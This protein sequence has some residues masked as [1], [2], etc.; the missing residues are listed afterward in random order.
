M[1]IHGS[2]RKVESD[3]MADEI[4]VCLLNMTI[5]LRTLFR[6]RPCILLLCL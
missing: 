4:E 1:G 3:D 5:K 2:E 6:T